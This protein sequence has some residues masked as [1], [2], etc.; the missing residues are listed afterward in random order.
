VDWWIDLCGA[1]VVGAACR[2]GSGD[3]LMRRREHTLYLRNHMSREP[4]SHMV[5]SDNALD[6]TGR[7]VWGRGCFTSV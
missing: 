3:R 5:L 7:S 6:T 2:Q 4:F 1:G